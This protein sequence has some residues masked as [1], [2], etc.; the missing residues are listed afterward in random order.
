MENKQFA[1]E[2]M[3]GFALWFSHNKGQFS[4]D[5]NLVAMKSYVIQFCIET[6]ELE[7]ENI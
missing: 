5:E 3:I 7:N 6:K 4:D 1:I 2:Q